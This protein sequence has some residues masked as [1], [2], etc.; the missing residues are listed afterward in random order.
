MGPAPRLLEDEDPGEG[1]EGREKSE[2]EKEERTL[3]ELRFVPGDYMCIAVLL[4]KNVNV[5]TGERERERCFYEGFWW[6]CA[7][8]QWMEGCSWSRRKRRWRLGWRFVWWRW[9]TY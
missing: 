5:V 3:V 9:Y 6:L 2:R 4:P 7:G 8:C 1:E